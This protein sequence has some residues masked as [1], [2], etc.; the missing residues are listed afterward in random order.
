MVAWFVSLGVCLRLSLRI[1]FVVGLC[2]IRFEF[3]L[4]I[5]KI[6]TFYCLDSVIVGCPLG[7]VFVDAVLRFECGGLGFVGGFSV[8]WV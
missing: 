3:I 2:L 1:F 8:F 4:F 6:I 5:Y 7:L